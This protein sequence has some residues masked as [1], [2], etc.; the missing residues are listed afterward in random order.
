MYGTG[1]CCWLQIM[2]PVQVHGSTP[3]SVVALARAL[4][5]LFLGQCGLCML[6][7][8]FEFSVFTEVNS[9]GC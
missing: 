8:A 3:A 1:D 4:N 6:S 2:F 7:T 5:T 9:V